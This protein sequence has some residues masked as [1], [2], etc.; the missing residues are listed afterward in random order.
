MGTG[1][2][3]G[4]PRWGRIPPTSFYLASIA[5]YDD[6]LV[7]LL[8]DV[9]TTYVGIRTLEKQIAIARANVVT[10]RQALALARERYKG[11]ATSEL[12]VYQA[13]NVLGTTQAT[14]PQLKNPTGSRDERAARASAGR[15]SPLASCL[16]AQPV[17]FRLLR[18]LS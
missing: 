1:F 13:E 16:P 7:T 9:A 5:N 2:L 18:G 17:S 11:G 15:R 3:G 4:V 6:V 10:Q 8:G 12:D 14:I